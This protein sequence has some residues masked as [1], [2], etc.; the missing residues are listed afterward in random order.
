LFHT[1]ALSIEPE[2]AQGLPTV[3]GIE[4]IREKG[5]Q[6]NEMIIEVHGGY[7][8]EPQVAGNFFTCAMGVDTTMKEQGRISMDEIALYEVQ[9]GKIIK[10]QFFY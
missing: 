9:H 3:K 4:K 7:C 2:H 8:L 10:E 5:K 6:W 1:E